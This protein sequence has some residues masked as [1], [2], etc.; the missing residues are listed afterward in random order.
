MSVTR[1]RL[2]RHATLLPA[3][4][5]PLPLLQGCGDNSDA[6]ACYDPELLGPGERQMRITQAYTDSAADPAS[7]CATCQFL[8]NAKAGCGHCEI[9]DGAVSTAGWCD[10]WALKS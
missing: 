6:R 5:A 1:R 10:A 9:L 4:A 3:V 8:H 7:S 2:L